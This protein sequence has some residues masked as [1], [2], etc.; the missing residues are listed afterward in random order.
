MKKILG[1]SLVLFAFLNGLS[2]AK[3]PVKWMASYKSISATEGE[4]IINAIIEKGWHTYSQKPITDG[5]L[6]T[7]FTFS[8]GK[9][10]QLVG[11]TDESE[12]EEEYVEAFGAKVFHFSNTAKFIQKVKITGKSGFSIAFKVEYMCCDNKMCLP[13]KTTDLSVKIQ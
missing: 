1:L 8:P 6:P 5:P 13:P 3:D 11:K 2:Q 10:Y 4:I 12:T 9:D 7:V